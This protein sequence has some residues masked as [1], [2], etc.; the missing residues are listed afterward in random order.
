MWIAST[1]GFFSIVQHRDL[2]DRI[3]VRSRVKKDL[4]SL[5][6][7]CRI[8]HTPDGDYHWRVLATKKEVG[9]LFLDSLM[10]INYSNFKNQVAQIPEQRDKLDAYHEIWRVMWNYSTKQ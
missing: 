10:N 3:M 1:S 4:E 9:E 6:D 8:I 2:P 5:F 7:L